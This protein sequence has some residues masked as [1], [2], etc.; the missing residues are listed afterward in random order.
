MRAEIDKLPER[1]KLVLSLY[2]DEGLTLA[3]IGQVLGVTE[4]R[5][6]QIHTK[7]VL[8]LRARAGR[9]RRR[10]TPPA[11]AIA[12][13]RLAGCRPVARRPSRRPCVRSSR[14]GRVRRCAVV[15]VASVAGRS[16]AP[17]VPCWPPPVDA[18]VVDPF[19]A[20]ACAWCPAI[21]ASST[22]PPPGSRCAAVGGRRR[23]TF[24]GVG[25]RHALRRRR[26]RRRAA[27]HV[28]R[29]GRPRRARRATSSWPAASSAR[30]GRRASTSG[31]A[32]GDDVRRSGAAASACWRCRP[33]LV[34][35]D[36]TAA[37]AGA[38]ADAAV[39]APSAV[40]TR[41]GAPIALLRSNRRIGR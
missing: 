32:R 4:S 22:A 9:R 31:C 35:T 40:A 26:P 23:S 3:E 37:A 11:L 41:D 18:P 15:L 24:A 33:R 7:A 10:L 1:E 16:P 38:A 5:V 27:G 36:G 20:P 12:G 25:R 30:A 28:R 14:R 19:R 21:G 8:H 13:V 29:P 34:P 2:Y 6:S 17:A 39:R